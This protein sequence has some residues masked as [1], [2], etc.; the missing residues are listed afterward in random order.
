MITD[1]RRIRS[2]FAPETV[3]ALEKA[4]SRACVDSLS[5]PV[6]YGGIET[7][8]ASLVCTVIATHGDPDE[9]KEL[10]EQSAQLILATIDQLIR[11]KETAFAL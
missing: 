7:L 8:M 10:A 6:D 1:I 2:Q 5:R 3:V 9:M 4:V 11:E